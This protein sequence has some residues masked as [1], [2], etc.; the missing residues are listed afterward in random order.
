MTAAWKPDSHWDNHEDYPTEDWQ[1]DVL[2]GGTRQSYIDWVN[3]QIEEDAEP[4]EPPKPS[5]LHWLNQDTNNA[6]C[7]FDA[8]HG[9]CSKTQHL[10]NCPDCLAGVST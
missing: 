7:G 4:V 8:G 2:E 9:R 1:D 6:V 5:K 10:V 3:S